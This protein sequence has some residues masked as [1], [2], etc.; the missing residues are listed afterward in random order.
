MVQMA[1]MVTV[2]GCSQQ[3][4]EQMDGAD[5]GLQPV[6]RVLAA[7]A[8]FGRGRNSELRTSA[9]GRRPEAIAAEFCVSTPLG[10]PVRT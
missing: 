3:R 4:R 6:P 5:A 1:C 10:A 2:A 7:F 9:S 8:N